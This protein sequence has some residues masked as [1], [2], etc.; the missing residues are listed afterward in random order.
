MRQDSLCLKNCWGLCPLNS[1]VSSNMT[2]I[3]WGY[4]FKRLYDDN[5]INTNTLKM[6]DNYLHLFHFNHRHCHG[7]RV[8]P[9]F[10]FDNMKFVADSIKRLAKLLMKKIKVK[11]REFKATRKKI[12][13]R[14]KLK[15]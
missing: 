7:S 3:H 4:Q 14:E 1:D 13:G 2:L 12:G 8:F 15:T 6:A 11:L 10:D 5:N 9:Y